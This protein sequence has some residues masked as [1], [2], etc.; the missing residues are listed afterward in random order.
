MA[1]LDINNLLAI[2][3]MAQKKAAKCVQQMDSSVAFSDRYFYF[4]EKAEEWDNV[5]NEAWDMLYDNGILL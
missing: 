2:H 5:A 3:A 1:T 4:S